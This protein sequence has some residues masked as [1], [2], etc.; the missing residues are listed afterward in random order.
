MEQIHW[1]QLGL[2]TANAEVG[3]NTR[4]GPEPILAFGLADLQL[5]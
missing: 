4:V 1:S 3:K 5:A 2:A